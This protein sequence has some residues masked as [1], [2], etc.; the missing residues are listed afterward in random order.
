[1]W[2]DLQVLVSNR[3]ELKSCASSPS[4][5]LESSNSYLRGLIH[6]L[7]GS[8]AT[9]S[10]QSSEELF[11]S[12]LTCVHRVADIFAQMN[13]KL[14]GDIEKIRT[15]GRYFVEIW[16]AIGMEGIGEKVQQLKLHPHA[17]FTSSTAESGRTLFTRYP[18]AG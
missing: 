3:R 8:L 18:F 2:S 5:I 17:C 14:G 4:S 12:I 7:A 16:K 11:P 13:N 10:S 6:I 9:I 15:T 1:M